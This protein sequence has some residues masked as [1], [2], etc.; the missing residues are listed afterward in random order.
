[1]RRINNRVQQRRRQLHVHLPPSGLKGVPYGDDKNTGAKIKTH[2]RTRLSRYE[3][4]LQPGL[5]D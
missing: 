4:H 5:A 1:M 2:H 3:H